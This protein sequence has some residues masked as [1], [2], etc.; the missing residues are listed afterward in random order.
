MAERSG[1]SP[2]AGSL[3]GEVNRVYSARAAAV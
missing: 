1:G 3:G 2:G